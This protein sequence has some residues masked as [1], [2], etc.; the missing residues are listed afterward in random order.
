MFSTILLTLQ[1]KVSPA[2]TVYQEANGLLNIGKYLDA[3]EKYTEAIKL[4][5][6]HLEAYAN[7]GLSY[8][9]IPDFFRATNADGEL[10]DPDQPAWDL[11]ID[12]FTA[13]IELDEKHQHPEIALLFMNRG[14]AYGN[15]NKPEESLADY[16]TAIQIRPDFA[17]AYCNRALLHYKQD[18]FDLAEADFQ[19]VLE[20]SPSAQA[21]EMARDMLE[22]L[23][24]MAQQSSSITLDESISLDLPQTLTIEATGNVDSK[25]I[26]TSID[27]ENES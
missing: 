4:D 16:N 11:A 12:D 17:E 22:K 27:E 18:R 2:E 7:R 14:F 26:S 9:S 13:A 21:G 23:S 1:S 5:S 8:T 25:S 3:I 19:K 6:R 24:E 20:L 10:I 15:F